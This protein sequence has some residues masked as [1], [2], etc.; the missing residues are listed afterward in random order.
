MGIEGGGQT[1]HPTETNS[2]LE[3]LKPRSGDGVRL[4]KVAVQSGAF[5]ASEPTPDDRKLGGVTLGVLQNEIKEG[6]PCLIGEK[7]TSPVRAIRTE[8]NRMLID[9]ET[10]TYE[11]TKADADEIAATEPTRQPSTEPVPDD[12]ILRQFEV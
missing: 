4:K 9:T 5:S 12:Q 3:E 10:T 11:V 7:K 1:K 6:E 2:N 8:G